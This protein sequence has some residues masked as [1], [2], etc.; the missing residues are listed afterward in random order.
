MP[1]LLSSTSAKMA[2]LAIT[3]WTALVAFATPIIREYRMNHPMN[4][5]TTV[6]DIATRLGKIIRLVTVLHLIL[7]YRNI[8]LF[9]FAT[10]DDAV[11][12]FAVIA[13]TLYQFY[14]LKNHPYKWRVQVCTALLL[15]GINLYFFKIFDS[16]LGILYI[17]YLF[18]SDSIVTYLKNT[19]Y[20]GATQ[21]VIRQVGGALRS[22]VD[23][24]AL[25]N[26]IHN[27]ADSIRETARNLVGGAGNATAELR[28]LQVRISTSRQYTGEIY[29]A[30]DASQVRMYA[31][32]A[33]TCL[34]IA[35]L[36]FSNSIG[37]MSWIRTLFNVAFTGFTLWK[38]YHDSYHGGIEAPLANQL[39]TLNNFLYDTERYVSKAICGCE[40]YRAT[41]SGD[42]DSALYY[43]LGTLL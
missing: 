34:L 42:M 14:F 43:G 15:L 24:R 22:G 23:L 13:S 12:R 26:Q 39:I 31:H 9:W 21:I 33:F 17:Y 41:K 25:R 27:L 3:L 10:D 35:S 40:A 36:Y 28:N 30:I 20:T 5:G 11:C 29:F 38:L 6:M 2:S 16:L 19:A 8:Y 7:A 4:A 18:T 1:L 37:Q 32:T